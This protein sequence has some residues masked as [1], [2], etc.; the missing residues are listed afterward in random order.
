MEPS[1]LDPKVRQAQKVMYKAWEEQNPAKRLALAHRAL[2]ISPDCA[3]A[4]VL[5]AEEEASS[6]KQAL[7]DYQK[8]VS[9]GERTLGKRYFR[10]NVGYFWGLLET[11]PYM[12]ALEGKARCLW[13]M[14]RHEEAL[15]TYQE[16]LRLNPNDN[17]GVRY[18]LVNLL[19]QLN[20]DEEVTKLIEEYDDDGSAVWLYTQALLAFR[21]RGP[22]AIANRKLQAAL[23]ENPHVVAYLTGQKACA[24]PA[25]GS[26]RVGRR[27]GGDRIR[28]RPSELLAQDA[29]S[30]GVAPYPKLQG[31]SLGAKISRKR[32][33]KAGD[34]KVV[35]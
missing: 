10:E 2:G 21:E 22:S 3:D 26:H 34:S 29:G 7:D 28:F 13:Q 23:D 35:A 24:T 15:S 25:S 6:V 19:L 31:P 20:R 4:Y 32:W 30:R 18:V 16:M 12:R 14:R 1:G 5:L 9:V 27:D 17:Q 33:Q 8:G 11:R